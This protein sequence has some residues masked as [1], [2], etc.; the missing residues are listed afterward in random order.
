MA[1]SESTM[2]L[3]LGLIVIVV[4]FGCCCWCMCNRGEDSPPTRVS[5]RAVGS[6]AIVQEVGEAEAEEMAAKSE[7][8]RHNVEPRTTLPVCTDEAMNGRMNLGAAQH[9]YIAGANRGQNLADRM[10]KVDLNAEVQ[11]L[12]L[13]RSGLGAATNKDQKAV[14]NAVTQGGTKTEQIK[15]TLALVGGKEENGETVALL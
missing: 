10:P 12:E 2:M 15:A 5:N 9:A 3:Y 11:M 14:L 7:P 1:D 8:R 4:I 13:L 6:K